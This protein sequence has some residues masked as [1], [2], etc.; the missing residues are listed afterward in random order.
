MLENGVRSCVHYRLGL[1]K[2]GKGLVMFKISE[3]EMKL[4]SG[5]CASV[6][7]WFCFGH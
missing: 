5:L 2:G 1:W 6:L 3:I 4:M 7:F